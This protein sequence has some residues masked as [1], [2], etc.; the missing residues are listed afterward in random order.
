MFLAEP[1]TT[2]VI[3]TLV[4]VLLAVSAVLSRASMRVGIPVVVLFLVLGM[5]VGIGGASRFSF[6]DYQLAFRLGTFALVLIL[7]DG[8]L[9]TPLASMRRSLLPAIMLAGPGV[10]ATAGLV[11]LGAHLLGFAWIEALLIGAI[12]S[13]TDAAAVFSV[14]RSSGLQLKQRVGTTVEVESGLND[15]MAFILTLMLTGNLVGSETHYLSLAA[16]VLLQLGIGAACGL[17]I[18]HGGR[19]LLKHFRLSAS[20]LYP[21][22]TLSLALLSFGLPTLLLGS[23]LLGAYV[24]GVVLGGSRPL[25]QRAS[26]LRT[27]D[28]VAWLAQ[29]VMFLALGLLIRPGQVAQT[30]ASGLGIAFFLVFV[31]RP[32][33]VALLLAPFRF[34]LREIVVI[35]WSGLRGAVPIILA[36]IPLLAHVPAGQRIFN[37]VFFV[38][39]ISAVVQGSSVRWL[40]RRLGLEE[41]APPPPPAAL[42]ISS[43]QPLSGEVLCFY[44]HRASAVAGAKVSELPFP[45]ESAAM[46]IIRGRDVLAPKGSTRFAPGDHVYVFCPPA[47]RPFM[48]LLF[49]QRDEGPA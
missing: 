22:L 24:A 15:P 43:L 42:E 38:V 46:L 44:V 28:F 30:A 18:G 2:A 5:L 17:A 12:V 14:L 10:V 32:L 29:I 16:H 6:T 20:G 1:A 8:G 33:V 37:I 11:G 31:A 13:S 48:E 19:F 49:G 41:R 34:S 35:G 36:L 9:N 23:G 27:H 3:M 25:P 47:D 39:V 26:L 45:S 4:G 40:T 21:I 7:F